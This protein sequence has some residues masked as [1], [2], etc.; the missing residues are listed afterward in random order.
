MIAGLTQT[1]VIAN[2]LGSLTL[3]LVFV[4]GG[5]VLPRTSIK[6]W[7]IWG[8]YISPLSYALN[9]VAVDEFLAPQWRKV[10]RT[11]IHYFS[12]FHHVFLCSEYA[13]DEC[14]FPVN[15]KY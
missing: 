13:S 14:S 4:L 15:S 1:L 6:D 5:F 3:L 11:G 10:G 12:L 9:G 8:Y 7:W 2:S